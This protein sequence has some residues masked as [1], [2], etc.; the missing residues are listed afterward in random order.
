MNPCCINILFI[1][2]DDGFNVSTEFSLDESGNPVYEF[3]VGDY[4]YFITYNPVLSRWE[5]YVVEE[6]PL[7]IFYSTGE[8]TSECP[9][10]SSYED[11]VKLAPPGQASPTKIE[12][13]IYTV[14]CQEVTPEVFENEQEENCE[15]YAPCKNKNLLSK[16]AVQLSKD[17]ASIS[18]QEV[19]GFNCEDAWNNIFMRS[20]IIDALNCLPYGTYSQE[21]EQ[22]LIGKLTDKCNC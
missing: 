18:K 20:L 6:E 17:I 14:D 9:Y 3:V 12:F 1:I 13:V 2:S 4:T 11:W 16:S 5:M 19:F 7:L 8:V 10:P 15:P 21:V 22:C